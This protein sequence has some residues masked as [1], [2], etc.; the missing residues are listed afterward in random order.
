LGNTKKF[1]EIWKLLANISY[2][3]AA[4]V[5]IL[6]QGENLFRVKKKKKI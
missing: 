5:E 3:F 1:S 2:T 6:F 4:C